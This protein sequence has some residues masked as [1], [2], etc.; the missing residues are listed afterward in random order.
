MMLCCLHDGFNGTV[1]LSLS[2][3]F[4]ESISEDGQLAI[5]L[6]ATEGFLGL[7][8]AGGG[9]SE[10]H[11]GAS[12]A[13]DVAG[14]LAHRAERVL[15]D[16]GAGER[17]PEFVRQAEADDGEDLLQPLQ[18]A[19]RDA[20]F[21]MLQTPDQVAQEPLGLVC[22]VLVPGLTE[23]L[24]D[25]RVQMF[26]QALD[27]VTALVDL[28]ALDG[29]GH[30]EGVSDRFAECLRA[31]DDEQPRQCRIE[32]PGEEIVDQGLD[33]DRVLHR[34][35]DHGQDMLVAV[36]ID[37]DRRHQDMVADMQTVDLDD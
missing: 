30:T 13:F 22:V 24:L 6:E 23:R 2:Q 5:C 26:G 16:V 7:Q 15:D 4:L 35:L 18:D 12:P 14:D 28:A 36:A 3:V 31:I 10:R 29:G 11:L 17:A 19:A 32:P 20:R 34:P 25:A 27:D 1:G 9:P 37:A 33:D 21:L 8:Q